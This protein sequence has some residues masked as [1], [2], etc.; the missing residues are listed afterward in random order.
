MELGKGRHDF[1][2]SS[3]LVLNIEKL[4]M[5]CEKHII[6]TYKPM[7]REQICANIRYMKDIFKAKECIGPAKG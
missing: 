5:K 3:W 4:M 6:I 7:N 2:L 1:H